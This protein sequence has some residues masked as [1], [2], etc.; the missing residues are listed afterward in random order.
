MRFTPMDIT[1]RTFSRSVRGYDPD[2]VK[3]FLQLISEDLEALITEHTELKKEL[4]HRREQLSDLRERE[5][6][7][8][9]TM[10]L[11]QETKE[12]VQKN[13]M[14]EGEIIVR[15][16][17]LQAERIVANA[18]ER[19]SEIQ[20]EIDDLIRTRTSLRKELES[21]IDK[22]TTFLSSLKDEAEETDS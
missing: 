2:E 22:T 11:A 6:I 9:D 17:E 21:L 16:S 12:Q 8:K 5:R 7:L 1:N 20:I 19:V 10:V 13:A 3:N 18:Y 4:E 14:K 15:E